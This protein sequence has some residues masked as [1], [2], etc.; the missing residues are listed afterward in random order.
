MLGIR[1]NI[2]TLLYAAKGVLENHLCRMESPNFKNDKDRLTSAEQCLTKVYGILGRTLDVTRSV[3]LRI[4]A[5]PHCTEGGRTNLRD[6]W[7]IVENGLRFETTQARVQVSASIP[8]NF[9]DLLCGEHDL[10]EAICLVAQN[11]I[12]A[13]KNQPPANATVA[14]PDKKLILRAEVGMGRDEPRAM[15]TIADNGPGISQDSIAQIFQPFYSTRH[16]QGGNGLGLYI[17]R[18]LIVKNGGTI[19]VS[20][21]EGCGCTFVID[22]PIAAKAENSTEKVA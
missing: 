16:G 17:A 7:F 8:R 11:A 13:L 22:L 21:F 5:K 2:I 9:P 6:I 4:K 14:W 15:I 19:N 3:G 18:Q 12:D 20:S 10:Q 1:H